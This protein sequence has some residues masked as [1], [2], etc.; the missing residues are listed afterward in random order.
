MSPAGTPLLT[1]EEEKEEEVDAGAVA[2]TPH[3]PV[4]P[5]K[6]VPT[7]AESTHIL[8]AEEPPF[9]SPTGSTVTAPSQEG[10]VPTE[11]TR[12]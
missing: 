8:V 7:P 12:M 3:S 4:E 9:L 11:D 1:E 6:H 5:P 2:V 10:G